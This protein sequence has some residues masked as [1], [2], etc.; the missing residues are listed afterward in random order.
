M[1]ARTYLPVNHRRFLAAMDTVRS[2]VP[3]FVRDCCGPALVERYSACV[4]ALLMWRRAHRQLGTHYLRGAS[5][6]PMSTA[7]GMSVCNR[8]HAAIAGF[9]T[10]MDERIDE[11]ARGRIA[12][13]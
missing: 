6:G 2:L 9:Q 10:L 3:A 13:W 12:R 11:T 8:E 4:D 7:T 5:S 1:K